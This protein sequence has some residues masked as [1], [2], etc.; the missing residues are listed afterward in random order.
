MCAIILITTEI[1]CLVHD[2][3]WEGIFEEGDVGY[4]VIKRQ[5]GNKNMRVKWGGIWE[6]RGH[7][8]GTSST[9]DFWK[10]KMET[11]Y[12]RTFLK[13]LNIWMKFK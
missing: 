9:K 5:R 6:K 4:S 3:E 13:Y 7:G 2:Q 11:C 12:C 10:A 8:G 1:R